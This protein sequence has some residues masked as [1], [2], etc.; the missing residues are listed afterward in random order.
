ML[1][2]TQ[3]FHF[4]GTLVDLI[5]NSCLVQEDGEEKAS[6]TSSNNHDM[7]VLAVAERRGL[8]GVLDRRLVVNCHAGYKNKGPKEGKGDE[9]KKLEWNEE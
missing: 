8:G 3:R 4:L 9:V 7:R 1:F 6:Q 2:F 5:R